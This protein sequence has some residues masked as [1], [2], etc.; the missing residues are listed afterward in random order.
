MSLVRAKIKFVRNLQFFSLK[1]EFNRLL[2]RDERMAAEL[3]IQVLIPNSKTN[4]ISSVMQNLSMYSMSTFKLLEKHYETADSTIRIFSWNSNPN[5]QHYF[6]P[7]AW[8]R[9]CRLKGW[10]F[11]HSKVYRFQ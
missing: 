3:E 1:L 5:S 7:I 2:E 4:P 10:R 11:G 6:S 8:E 9:I